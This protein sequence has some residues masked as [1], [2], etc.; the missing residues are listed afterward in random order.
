ML[1][2]NLFARALIEKT[3][4]IGCKASALLDPHP[5]GPTGGK[6]VP[7]AKRKAQRVARRQGRS[8]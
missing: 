5:K 2:Q 6:K 4:F 8:K 3:A 1:G 7:K